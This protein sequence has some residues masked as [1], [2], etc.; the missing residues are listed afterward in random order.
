MK[1]FLQIEE[2]IFST[3]FSVRS[4]NIKDFLHTEEKTFSTVF[5]VRSCIVDLIGKKDKVIYKVLYHDEIV[6]YLLSLLFH[7]AH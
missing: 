7:T 1:G 4:H 5:S 2:M 6:P 3:V